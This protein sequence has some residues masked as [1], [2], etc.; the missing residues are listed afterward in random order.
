MSTARKLI[1]YIVY[2]IVL[3]ALGVGV[4]LSLTNHDT[5]KVPVAKAPH[6][7]SKRPSQSQ[8]SD[9]TSQTPASPATTSPTTVTAGESTR[10]A[11]DS[12]ASAAPE[13]ANT[14]PGS[15]LSLFV[16][17]SVAAAIVYRERL[18]RTNNK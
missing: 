11:I 12:A 10:S 2:F 8:K 16:L 1:L 7:V 13:L 15:I 3:I 6:S 9:D 5:K 18:I 14:G 17:T 4:F